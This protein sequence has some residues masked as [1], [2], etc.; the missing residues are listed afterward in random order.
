[1][2]ISNTEQVQIGRVTAIVTVVT[3]L[4]C[5]QSLYATVCPSQNESNQSRQPS[6][7]KWEVLKAFWKLLVNKT[8]SINL[9]EK[10][11]SISIRQK[12][13][14]PIFS[15]LLYISESPIKGTP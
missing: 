6:M 3:E 2:S 12:R 11:S 14:F 1:M 15:L 7:T 5:D 8:A 13:S 4:L 10:L 9:A